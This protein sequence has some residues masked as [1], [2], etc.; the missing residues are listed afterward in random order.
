MFFYFHDFFLHRFR[1]LW[2]GSCVNLESAILSKKQSAPLTRLTFKGNHKKN[3]FIG[4]DRHEK[5]VL[6][7]LGFSM[8]NDPNQSDSRDFKIQRRDGNEKVA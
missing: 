1:L 7:L 8:M 3:K 4:N 5:I 6:Q 2:A